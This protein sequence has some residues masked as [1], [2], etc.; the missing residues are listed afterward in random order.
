MFFDLKKCPLCQLELITNINENY[1]RCSNNCE[2]T[3]TENIHCECD[4]E[5][6]HY[7]KLKIFGIKG[8]LIDFFVEDYLINAEY[9]NDLVIISAYPEFTKRDGPTSRLELKMQLDEFNKYMNDFYKFKNKLDLFK[10]Y[11]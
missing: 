11:D 1:I 8:N 9:E 7:C 6:E 10:F 5:F 4:L 2:C 3:E